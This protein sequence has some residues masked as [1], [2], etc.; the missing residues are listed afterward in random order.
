M[1]YNYATMIR[2]LGGDPPTIEALDVTSA[3]A[4]TAE[5]PQ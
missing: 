3:V 2:G 1:K 5:Y 4:D